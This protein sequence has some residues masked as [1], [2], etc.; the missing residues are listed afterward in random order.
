MMSFTKNQLVFIQ[1]QFQSYC[2]LHIFIILDD[3]FTIDYGSALPKKS[4]K[5]KKKRKKVSKIPKII[6]E[7][8]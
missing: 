3:I 5:K 4:N 2:V 8:K 1:R 7:I 6:V